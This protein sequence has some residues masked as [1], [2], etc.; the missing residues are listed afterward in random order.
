M[1]E[2]F[3][4]WVVGGV[5]VAIGIYLNWLWASDGYS[6]QYADWA[7]I[8]GIMALVGVWVIILFGFLLD[9]LPSK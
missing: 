7:F 6:Y 5:F 3:T 1:I 9:K 2:D 8:G 4:P